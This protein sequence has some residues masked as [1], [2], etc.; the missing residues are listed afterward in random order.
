MKYDLDVLKRVCVQNKIELLVLFGSHATG[1]ATSKSD[2]DIVFFHLI[3][4]W[5]NKNCMIL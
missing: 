5:M 4:S 1:E 3:N 2:L